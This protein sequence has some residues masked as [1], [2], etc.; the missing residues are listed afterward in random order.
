MRLWDLGNEVP[1]Y[2]RALLML[3]LSLPADTDDDPAKWVIGR[4]DARLFD[5][6]EVLFGEDLISVVKCRKCSVQLEMNLKTTDLRVPDAAPDQV[7]FS[8][9]LADGEYQGTLRLPN[10]YDLRAMANAP[11]RE[12]LIR[13]CLCEMRRDDKS[14]LQEPFSVATLD[15]LIQQIENAD[16]Q[17]IV[18]LAL[19]CADCKYKWLSIFDIVSY[20]WEEIRSLAEITMREVHLLASTYGWSEEDIIS[21]NRRRRQRYLEIILE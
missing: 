1:H 5:L 21:M 15:A 8:F 20:L 13:R 16:P 17:A 6:R 19:T 2:E 18:E 11:S 3:A 14:V 7:N 10:S 12:E 9:T 4:R